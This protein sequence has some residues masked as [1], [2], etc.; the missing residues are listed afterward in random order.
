M[1]SRVYHSARVT[2]KTRTKRVK[3]F[4]FGVKLHQGVSEVIRHQ[5]VHLTF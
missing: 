4:W 5:F 1:S 2:T 3:Q